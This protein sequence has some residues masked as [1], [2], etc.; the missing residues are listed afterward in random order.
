MSD[1]PFKT[2]TT[3]GPPRWQDAPL[4]GDVAD[5]QAAEVDR[6]HRRLAEACDLLK[7]WRSPKKRGDL[8]ERT[9]V[10]LAGEFGEK[11]EQ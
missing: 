4:L 7:A 8:P 5:M 2:T 3:S 1:N 10:F 9:R 11:P 6:L